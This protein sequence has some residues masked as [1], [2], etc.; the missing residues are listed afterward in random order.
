MLIL[1]GQQTVQGQQMVQR[2][3]QGQGQGLGQIQ[4]QSQMLAAIAAAQN[5]ALFGQ[6]PGLN[7]VYGGLFAN[8]GLINPMVAGALS[9][10]VVPSSHVPVGTVGGLGSYGTGQSLQHVYPNAQGKTHGTGGSF[11]GYT[12]SYMWYDLQISLF[13]FRCGF[14]VLFSVNLGGICFMISNL[15][16]K[17][18]IHFKNLNIILSVFLKYI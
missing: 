4:D 6:H 11:P 14:C 2:N 15:L 8:P 13:H 9:Q 16:S 5:L 7:P 17:P 10:A 12:S 3:H 1:Q 18:W